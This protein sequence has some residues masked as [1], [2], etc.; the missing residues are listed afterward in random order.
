MYNIGNPVVFMY[1]MYNMPFFMYN[2]G[3]PIQAN[4][5]TVTEKVCYV[6]E[7]FLR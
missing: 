4:P 1:N 7:Y 2:I 5:F 6:S 3:S